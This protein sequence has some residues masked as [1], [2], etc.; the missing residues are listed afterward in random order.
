VSDSKT[1]SRSNS[2]RN[3]DGEMVSRFN[4]GRSQGYRYESVIIFLNRRCDVGCP[5][6]NADAK[7]HESEELSIPQ[8]SILL[9]RLKGLDF[10]GYIVWTGG[11]PFYSIESLL[12]GVGQASRNGFHS[13]IL[14]GGSWFSP[15]SHYLES[16]S[17]VPGV[18]LRISVDP[19]HQRRIPFSQ[20]IALTRRALELQIGVNYT[21]RRIPGVPDITHAFLEEVQRVLPDYYQKNHGLSRWI[22]YN[23]HVPIKPAALSLP[24]GS[25][26]GASADVSHH[27]VSVQSGG[28]ACKMVFRDVVIGND[29]F[30]YPCCGLF[31]L[32]PG[33]RKGLTAGD[34]GVETWEEL[35]YRHLSRHLFKTLREKGP[36]GLCLESKI[37]PWEWGAGFFYNPCHLC[38]EVLRRGVIVDNGFIK[39]E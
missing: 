37:K 10:S 18:S 19:E 27:E 17:Q 29:G 34:P 35:T 30:M 14:T 25:I 21:F 38:L 36:L 26:P 39:N 32:P 16:L 13:E 5:S 23:P 3:S 22:H 4:P 15:G 20:V 9:D 28:G 8:L 1:Y 2:N 24:R 31:T 33:V 6:C 11:E 7:L 12:F